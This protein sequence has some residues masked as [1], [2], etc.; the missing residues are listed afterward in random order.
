MNIRLATVRDI[1]CLQKLEKNHHQEELSRDNAGKQGQVFSEAD[2]KTLIE[3][4][5]IVL[6]EVDSRVVGYVIAGR[7]DFFESWP[8]YRYLLKQLAEA[9]ISRKQS[10]QYGPIWIDS[11]YR[12]Q[13]IFSLLVKKLK[14]LLKGEFQYMCTF[15]AEDNQRSYAAHTKK[16][17][18]QVID[19]FD[20]H[21]QGYYLLSSK[22]V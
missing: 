15:I 6:A 8:I 19:F 13:G 18:M 22:L 20:F 2:L 14:S 11:D 16:A 9:G 3:K 12:G 1:T 10:C 5:W 7:W 17:Q 4:H 21:E